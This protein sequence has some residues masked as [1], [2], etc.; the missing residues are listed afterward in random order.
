MSFARPREGADSR[1]AGPSRWP[2]AAPVSLSCIV[3]AGGLGTRLREAVPD[4]PKCLAPVGERSFVELQLQMLRRRG[5]ERFVL[6][7]HHEAHQVV[8]AVEPLAETL[9]VQMLVEPEL[10]GTGGAVAYAMRSWGL[11]E[12]LVTNGD[13]WLDAD[14]QPMFQPL[15][16]AGG[17]QLRLATVEVADRARYGGVEVGAGGRV[18]RFIGKGCEGPGLI[19]AGF[20]RLHA[21]ALDVAGA[22]QHFSLESDVLPALARAGALSAVRLDGTFIDI[23]VPEDYRRFCAMQR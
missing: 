13:T 11:D 4:R 12:A 8:R 20:Y 7:L 1:P 10:L 5:V 6:S 19:N 3:L 14:L 21:D 16:R 18:A 17:E 23:G 15:D 2:K 9:K 22:R